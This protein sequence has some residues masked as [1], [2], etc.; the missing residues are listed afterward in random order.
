MTEIEELRRLPSP[1][2]KPQAIAF[3]G[4]RLWIGSRETS[5]LYSIDPQSWNARD[6]GVAPGVPWG[7]AVVGDELRII[8]GE[9]EED[10]RVIRRFIPGHGF[11]HDSFVAPDNGTGSHLSFDGDRLYVSQ[12]YNKRILSLDEQGKVGTVLTLHHEI[13]GHT[14]VDGKF[15]CITTDDENAHEYFLTR[16]DARNGGAPKIDDIARLH[17][18]ARGLAFDGEKFW[19]NH[20][21]QNETVAFARPDASA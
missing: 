16:V 14:I 6:E 4:Q 13:A 20:R 5:R 10:V 8:C 17:F 11:K 21:E 15:Y 19:T 7:A 3:D 18:D 2:P 1:V 12:W 9:G